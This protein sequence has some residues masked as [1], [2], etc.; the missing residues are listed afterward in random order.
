MIPAWDAQRR[1]RS[2]IY[3]PLLEAARSLENGPGEWPGLDD[4]NRLLQ[5]APAPILTRSGK[6]LRF[7]PQ[8]NDHYEQR[9]Y[10]TGEVQTRSKNWHDLFNAL[11]WRVFPKAK[12]IINHLHYQASLDT[13]QS[14]SGRGTARDVLTL[15][16]ESGVAIACAQDELGEMLRKRQWKALFW[17]HRSDLAEKMKF[18]IFG[19]SLYEKA[20]HPY[21]GLTGKAL[22][23]PVAPSFF[24]L[25]KALQLAELDGMIAD[26]LSAS[27]SLRATSSL[28]PLPLLGVPG[29]WPDNGNVAFYENA[30][31]FRPAQNQTATS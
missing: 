24:S 26:Y 6:P 27:G 14:A 16:D 29:W 13:P 18:Y 1:L 2:Q 9:T 11:V 20:L 4:L 30:R 15:F 22:I 31:Y 10:L 25:P 28:I 17:Q 12:A 7:A 5:F 19:H 8:A 21:I 3:E 23:L